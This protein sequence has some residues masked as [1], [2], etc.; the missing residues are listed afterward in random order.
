MTTS[1][2]VDA[3]AV[4][5]LREAGTLAGTLRVRVEKLRAEADG[6]LSLSL[7]AADG[8]PLPRWEP[9]A[10][11]DLLLAEGL[12]RQYSLCGFPQDTDRWQVAVLRTPDGRGGS[13]W[14]HTHLRQGDQL[15][16]RGPRNRFPLLPARR[17]VFVAGGI[18]ITPLM[19][20]LRQLA[21]RPETSWR[22]V[23]GGRRRASM[24]FLPELERFGDRVTVWPQDE[25]G[26]L[27]LDTA[28]GEPEVGVAIYCCGPEALIGAVERRCRSW[29][30]GTLHVERF[31]ARDAPD[32][33][34]AGRG[35]LAFEV[36]AARSGVAVQ[37]A[38]DRTIV[39]TLAEHG[40][41]IPVSCGEGVCGTCETAV[42]DGVPDHRDAL[43]S[44]AEKEAG[45]TMMPCCSRA[46]TPRLV[47]DV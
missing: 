26:L 2:D 4:A 17:Y 37:V 43:L 36:V 28:L 39:D 29:P 5:T 6:V 42:L 3:P 20:M 10:H 15:R 24:A 31:A 14:I 25:R 7:V 38:G 41:H 21:A 11:I 13:E 44:D 47:L 18:G 8:C 40:I 35:N 12:E 34:D 46:R 33:P 32:A 22:L 19:P 45:T 30:P 27:D 23:Y 16:V 1:R 9:G